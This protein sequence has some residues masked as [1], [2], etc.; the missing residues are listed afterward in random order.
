VRVRLHYVRA[1]LLAVCVAV[2]FGT[3]PSSAQQSNTI[4]LWTANVALA[5]VH[6]DFVRVADASAAGG[7]ALWNPD[8]GVAKILPA[9]A[10]PANYIELAFN[11][12]AGVPYHIWLRMKAENDSTANDSFHL[13]FSDSVTADGA[14][15]TRIGTTD[16]LAV[17]LQDGSGAP[18]PQGWG[19]SDNGW[20][21]F[22]SP[23]Y[24]GTTGTH[25]LRIQQRED[26]ASVDQIVISPDTYSTVSPGSTRD[27]RTI[28]A[29]TQSLSAAAILSAGTIV[30]R[31]ADVSASRIFGDWHRVTDATAD[32]GADLHN[33]DYGAA[34]ISPALANPGTYFETTFSAASGQPYHVWL[35]LKADNDSPYNDS[36]H[37]QFND[38]L[39]STG[40]DMARIGTTASAEF[41]LQNGPYGAA[42]HGWGWTDNGWGALG[43]DVYFAATGTHTLR[44]QQREDGVTVD[45]IVISPDAYLTVPPGS[46]QDDTTLLAATTASSVNQPPVV[47]LSSP[48]SD[49]TFTAPA[50]ISLGATASDPEN[51]MARVE[52]YNGSTLLGTDTT[53]PY[54]FS[55]ASVPTG[56]YSLT[57]V[58]YDLDGAQ[59]R[60][61][62]VSVTVTSATSSGSFSHQD[63]GSPAIAGTATLS[64]GL[65]TDRKS[66]V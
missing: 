23:V 7:Y 49:A 39:T 59:T 20:G 37:L 15:I 12:S 40:S 43:A 47:A 35:R 34:K 46:R 33:P 21:T 16:S 10:A 56:T 6:G 58:A 52:F 44:I 31:A 38:S 5:D 3:K 45:Q 27:D 2:L 60:S 11:A 41:I 24:F 8:R 42:P 18:A 53:S 62:P 64:N 4:V 14:A 66:V 57:A 17:S 63:I 48:A 51:R 32:G 30:L 19:W 54:T 25:I 61:A 29:A 55:W 65:Y 50:T 36:V 13:Q 26:G 28:L 1:A 9:L 22:G